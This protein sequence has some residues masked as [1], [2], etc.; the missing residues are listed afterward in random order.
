MPTPPDD[1]RTRLRDALRELKASA[2][3]LPELIAAF[4]ER[5]AE[6]EGALNAALRDAEQAH[7][8]RDAALGQI[9]E[10]E[11][12]AEAVKARLVATHAADL[13]AAG[14]RT[15]EAAQSATALA[16]DVEAAVQA[17]AEAQRAFGAERDRLA[18]DL[19]AAQ[20][21][22]RRYREE[23]DWLAREA[24]YAEKASTARHPAPTP[25]KP[26]VAGRKSPAKSSAA[27]SPTPAPP[28]LPE[29]VSADAVPEPLQSELSPAAAVPSSVEAAI[30][31]AFRVWCIAASPVVGKVEFF[32]S[33]LRQILPGAT[34]SSV[35]RD[36][37][38]QS[39]PVVIRR[40][41]GVI[42]VEHWL[43]VADG[44]H[45][46]LPQ[47]LGGAQFRELAPC[48]EGSAAPATLAH[49]R[50]ADV[51]AVGD[52]FELTRAGEVA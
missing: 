7:H 30:A 26:A 27:E 22:A 1:R 29:S 21:D 14:R 49:V 10:G 19:R 12:G 50:P 3:A 34:V 39:M 44:R 47:P 6:Q 17:F 36:V 38:S 28:A 33:H 20:D 4:E 23:R 15:E 24:L 18:A 41:S 31:E 40:T 52:Q 32:G 25:A 43:V 37:N 48:F 2:A 11:S 5:L 35:Y 51:R 13:A 45:W 16:D 8:G 9:R 42:P 46:L